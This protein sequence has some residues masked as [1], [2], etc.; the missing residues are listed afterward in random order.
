[1]KRKLPQSDLH[2][3]LVIG[4]YISITSFVAEKIRTFPFPQILQS[5]FTIPCDPQGTFYSRIV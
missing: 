4:L 1:M 2:V 5:L 3:W